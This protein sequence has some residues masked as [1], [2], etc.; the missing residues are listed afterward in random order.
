MPVGM[1]SKDMQ[2]Q[3]WKQ[4]ICFSL[5]NQKH[6][7]NKELCEACLKLCIRMGIMEKQ[8]RVKLERREAV[9]EVLLPLY[10]GQLERCFKIE[11]CQAAFQ[12]GVPVSRLHPQ[13]EAMEKGQRW[14][15]GSGAS[16]ER[17]AMREHSFLQV[18]DG[19]GNSVHDGCIG[20]DLRHEVS[21]QVG[22][23]WGAFSRP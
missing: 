14:I 19:K 18:E 7:K 20:Q 4:N 12:G 16:V 17:A 5:S 8:E 22:Q 1:L 6:R 3:H 13:R 2:I 23:A 21:Q 15:V 10:P 11:K 9:W